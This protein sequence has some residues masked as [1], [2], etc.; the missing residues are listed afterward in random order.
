MTLA[1]LLCV[2][3]LRF[4]RFGGRR[5]MNKVK[6]LKNIFKCEYAKMGK[7]DN[8]GGSTTVESGVES[9]ERQ[10]SPRAGQVAPAPV[11]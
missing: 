7:L 3:V 10:A 2:Y 1:W 6:H 9:E 4:I 5:G 11:G 8:K